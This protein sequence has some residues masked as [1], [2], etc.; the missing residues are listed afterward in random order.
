MD[1]GSRQWH[2]VVCGMLRGNAPA[3]HSVSHR[4]V[5]AAAVHGTPRALS[6]N[7]GE[8]CSRAI[9]LG[10]RFALIAE[11]EDS[12][13]SGHY[14][15]EDCRSEPHQGAPHDPP[16]LLRL[17]LLRLFF[18]R[19]GLRPAVSAGG[20]LLQLLAFRVL[21][22]CLSLLACPDELVMERGRL[23]CV[24]GATSGPGLGPGDAVP[25]E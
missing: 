14:R 23:G 13:A 20:Y 7:V 9:A 6:Q 25:E 1:Q 4:A 10:F 12:S 18:L 24:L 3:C 2:A 15:Q 11:G 19:E 8:G 21:M 5:H 17:A 22:S 16:R